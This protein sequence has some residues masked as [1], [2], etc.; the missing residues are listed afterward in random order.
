MRLTADE[1][2]WFLYSPEPPTDP[3]EERHDWRYADSYYVVVGSGEIAPDGTLDAAE[4]KVREA[5]CRRC[6]RVWRHP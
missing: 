2:Q 1:L 5:G 6:G 3:G 4:H